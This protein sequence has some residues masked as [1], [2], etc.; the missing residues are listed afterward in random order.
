MGYLGCIGE[1][2]DTLLV[3]AVTLSAGQPSS[4]RNCPAAAVESG[5]SDTGLMGAAL[6]DACDSAIVVGPADSCNS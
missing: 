1:A 3:A 5:T 4:F 6:A 2:S